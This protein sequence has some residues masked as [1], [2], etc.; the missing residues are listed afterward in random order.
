[1]LDIDKE[2]LIYLASP[3][4][5]DSPAVMEERFVRVCE[6][7]AELLRRGYFVFSPIASSVPIV[8]YGGAG[9]RWEDWAEFDKKFL[10]HC[11]DVLC[12]LM[13]DNWDQSV[14]VAAEVTEAL[15]GCN[16]IYQVCGLDPRTME[17]CDLPDSYFPTWTEPILNGRDPF[18]NLSM[19]NRG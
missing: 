7:T 1:M 14:G 5:H 18:E 16:S 19:D 11:V 10:S 17:F 4:T 13:L 9:H 3:Y 12:V 15:T 8:K 2:S 6:A